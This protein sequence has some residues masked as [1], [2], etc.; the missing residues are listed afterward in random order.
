MVLSKSVF[1]DKIRV[2]I[3]VV[4]AYFLL[5]TT[6]FAVDLAD[7]RQRGVLRHL[8]VPYANFVTASGDGIDGLDVVL[9]R[10][11]AEHLGVR[12]ELVT[13]SWSEAFGDLTGQRVRPKGKEVTVIGESKVR[14]D[15]LANGLTILP[16]REK[17]VNYSIPTFPTG[18]WL[19]ARADSPIKPIEPSGDMETDIRRVMALI[20][21]RSVLTVK[22]TC[23]DADLYELG[24]V[25]AEIRF[26]AASESLNDIVPSVI[27]GAAETALLDIPDALVALQKWPGE[28]KV[29]GPVSPPQLMGVAVAKSSP[30][31]LQAFNTFFEA[32]WNDGTYEGLVRKYYPAIFLYLGD[33]FNSKRGE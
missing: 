10:L 1:P 17:V 30:E 20:R 4:W 6:A 2:A 23:L 14:G 21:E 9:I 18:V 33:F 24:A 31:L 28:I 11:F 8:G 25:G 5:S 19:V 3:A 29:V 22:G 13:T 27:N 32:C 15:I 26:H 7:I 12:Y 16:W